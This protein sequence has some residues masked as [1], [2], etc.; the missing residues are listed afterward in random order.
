M[1]K[2]N[3][4]ATIIDGIKFDSKAEAERYEELFQ[5]YKVGDIDTLE[6]HPRIVLQPSFKYHGKTERLIVYEADFRYLK[7]GEVIVEDVKGFAT[8]TYKLKR[9]LL[10]YRYPEINF[11]QLDRK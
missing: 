2:Y 9:K 4:V 6:V 10:L 7:N 1:N 11:I 3:A 5:M 8:E